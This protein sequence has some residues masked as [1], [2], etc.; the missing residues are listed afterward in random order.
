[1]RVNIF[2]HFFAVVVPVSVL[3]CK[4]LYLTSNF[5]F[6][7]TEERA[8]VMTS[9][10]L[11]VTQLCILPFAC[12]I[13]ED[14][15]AYIHQY[16]ILANLYF[17]Q[18]LSSKTKL[19]GQI[20]SFCQFFMN[21]LKPKGILMAYCIPKKFRGLVQINWSFEVALFELIAHC[22]FLSLSLLLY[23]RSFLEGELLP[24]LLTACVDHLSL[25]DTQIP[26]GLLERL[27]LINQSFLLQFSD[28][29]HNE[30]VN[31]V[32]MR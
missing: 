2:S 7:C 14:S 19:F 16:V 20:T 29:M 26:V 11:E 15:L 3:V 32:Y 9:L 24:H 4:G 1:M 31:T 6:R 23:N 18:I 25:A 21:M 8:M 5:A 22:R 13:S 10:I 17:L 30:K 28:N 12:D 27:C